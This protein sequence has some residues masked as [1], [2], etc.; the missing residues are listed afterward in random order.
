MSVE[1]EKSDFDGN[2]LQF[3]GVKILASLLTIFTLGFGYPWAKCMMVRWTVN[4]SL[5]EGRRL[6][7]HGTGI[8]LFGRWIL[9]VLLTIIT[10]GIYGFWVS[11]A[12]EKWKIKNTSFAD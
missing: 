12:M 6:K 3:I 9:W 2:V 4:H 7:F 11:I 5:I 10:I 1:I 8:G